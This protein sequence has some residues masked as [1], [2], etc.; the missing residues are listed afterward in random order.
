LGIRLL[1]ALLIVLA[2]LF[3]LVTVDIWY[4]TRQAEREGPQ[5]PAP[6]APL[7]PPPPHVDYR[8]VH[9]PRS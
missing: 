7:L 4:T 6:T 5:P 3:T 8:R 1:V 2:L 9:A